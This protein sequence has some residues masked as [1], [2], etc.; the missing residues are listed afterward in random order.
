MNIV[1]KSPDGGWTTVIEGNCDA[2]GT[3]YRFY[4]GIK[5][6]ANSAYKVTLQG[7]TEIV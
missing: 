6:N 4:A 3:R 1:G 7:I 2:C 5:E